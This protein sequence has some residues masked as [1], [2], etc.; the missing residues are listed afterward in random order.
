MKFFSKTHKGKVRSGNEDSIYAGDYFAIVADGMGGHNA[1][2]VASAL[3]VDS[4]KQ[5]LSVIEPMNVTSKDIVKA[6]SGANK[7]V[8]SNAK[9]N[10]ARDGM[11]STA[12][13]AVFKDSKVLIGQVG[14]SRAYLYSD[15]V[16]SQIT[17]D[18]SYV[19]SLV[20]SGQITDNEALSH[21]LRNVITRAIGTN[22]DVE[23]DFFAQ[24]ISLGDLVLICSDGLIACVLDDDISAI[25]SEG[26]TGAADKLVNAALN[27][28]GSDN[29]SVIIASVEGGQI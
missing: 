29:I 23:C 6:I 9:Q 27:C 20:D 17:K 22:I 16:L 18:H 1:G 14:D 11:G 25:L 12:T 26:V 13:L 21:P 7:K 28:G 4:I 2:D 10:T 8:W 19:Q 3:V 24:D 15:G 5:A